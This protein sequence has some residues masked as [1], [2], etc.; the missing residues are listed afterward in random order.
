MPRNQLPDQEGK[1]VTRISKADIAKLQKRARIGSI[2]GYLAI[3][4]LVIAALVTNVFG[5]LSVILGLLSAVVAL[6]LGISVRWQVKKTA[7]KSEETERIRSLA[8]QSLW[9]G[10]GL[11]VAFGALTLVGLIL[12]A[13]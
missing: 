4:L 10:A 8:T 9:L 2:F 5:F 7:S 13:A 3:P 12:M 6:F 11:L 1:L